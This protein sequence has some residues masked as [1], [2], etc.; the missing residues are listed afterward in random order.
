VHTGLWSLKMARKSKGHF[1]VVAQ[2]PTVEWIGHGVQDG[3]NLHYR[4]A[5]VRNIIVSHG[6]DY[7]EALRKLKVRIQGSVSTKQGG[8]AWWKEVPF[9][10]A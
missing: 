4:Y 7:I 6:P 2:R 8:V 5:Q 9:R 10:G 3:W 1:P